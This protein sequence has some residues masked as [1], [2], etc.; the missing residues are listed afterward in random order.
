MIWHLIHLV[1]TLVWDCLRFSRLSP[2]DKTLE[3]LLL[4][5]QILILRRHQKRGPSIMRSEKLILL[6]LVEHFRDFANLQK[7]QLEQLILIF[8]PDTL[9]RWHRQL[10]KRK[11]TFNHQHQK[12]GRPPTEPQVVQLVLQ[13]A[14][15]NRWGDDRIAGELKKLGYR[16]SHE[17]VRKIL[18][19]HGILPN[20]HQKPSSTWRKF[21]NHY[22]ETLLACDFFTVETIRLQTLFVFF[23][24]EVGTRRVHIAGVTGHPTQTWVS[25][26]ARQLVWTLRA[27][28]RII[29]HLIRDNDGKHSSTFDAVLAS[30]GIEIVRTPYR[31]PRANAYAE[32]WVRSVREECLDQLLILNQTHLRYVLREYE[33]Y[34]NTAR[35]HQGLRQKIPDLPVATSTTGRIKRRERLGGVLH[36]YYRVA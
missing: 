28:D 16:I 5:Q 30:E 14:R 8:K 17:T 18:R 35:P 24:I 13:F 32:R 27:S 4:R 1:V 36:D 6:T 23:F 11:W 33:S 2:D 20:P 29:T 19:H 15:E 7:A 10:V 26:Q 21:E 9:L 34:F 3:L 22:R 31:A 25:Q 12:V